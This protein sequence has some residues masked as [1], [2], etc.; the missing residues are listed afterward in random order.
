[1]RVSIGGR[2]PISIGGDSCAY[3]DLENRRYRGIHSGLSLSFH[4]LL[5]IAFFLYL[6]GFLPA[7]AKPTANAT[8]PKNNEI[9]PQTS[10]K[11]GAIVA[12]NTVQLLCQMTLDLPALEQYFHPT[13]PSRKPLRVIKNDAVKGDIKLTKFNLP[14]EFITLSEANKQKKPYFE[15]TSIEVKDNTATVSF[16]YRVEGIRGKVNFK[17]DGAWQVV[18]HELVEE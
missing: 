2:S 7:C 15:F 1:M 17:R 5:I 6:C 8:N 18:S 10:Q 9:L 16:R 3:H 13:E 4:G 12:A 11:S 14:V